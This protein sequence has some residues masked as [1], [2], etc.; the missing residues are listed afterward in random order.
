MFVVAFVVRLSAQWGCFVAHSRV[1]QIIC[2][3]A[4]FGKVL[5]G[6]LVLYNYI[7]RHA[8]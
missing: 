3:A 8:I 6:F 4:F 1:A 5:S 7:N 2:S